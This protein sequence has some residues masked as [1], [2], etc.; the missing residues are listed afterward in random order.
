MRACHADLLPYEIMRR[1]DNMQYERL[2][3]L[4]PEECDGCGACSHVCPAGLD[5]TAKV[6]EARDAHGNIFLNW[7][8]GDDL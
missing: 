3:S 6:L 7:G 8:D 2:A 1:L 4:L 5:V